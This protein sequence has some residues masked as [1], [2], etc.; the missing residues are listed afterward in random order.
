MKPLRYV[1]PKRP[2]IFGHR[3]ASIAAP[4]N[5]LAAFKLAIEQGADGVELD[6]HLSKDGVPIVIHDFSVDATT[7]SS[8]I[9][10]DLTLAELQVLDAGSWFGDAFAGEPIPTLNEV[11]LAL[12][13][14]TYINVEIKSIDKNAQQVVQA[15]ANVIASHNMQA[16]VIVSSFN[17]WALQQFRQALP[18]VPLG[19]LHIPALWPE[20]EGVLQ[21]TAY[22]YYHPHFDMVLNDSSSKKDGQHP[23]NVWTVNDPE[24]AVALA[25]K[26]VFGIIT[27]TPAVIR[28]T[29]ENG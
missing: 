24:Q 25:K 6:V 10:A 21:P 16:H 27:D 5:T 28:K 19:W 2:L 7:N 17:P 12:A 11:F 26:G 22:D 20:V 15:V 4:M 18:D 23:L 3:G 13:G 1:R 29:L 9:V 14:H 8:G